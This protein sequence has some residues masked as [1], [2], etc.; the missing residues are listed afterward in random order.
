MCDAWCCLFGFLFN[1]LNSP[2]GHSFCFSRCRNEVSGGAVYLLRAA[3]L[4]SSWHGVQA[5]G[6]WTWGSEQS[7]TPPSLDENS[8]SFPCL[9]SGFPITL[10]FEEWIPLRK[11]LCSPDRPIPLCLLLPVTDFGILDWHAIPLPLSLLSAP[12]PT[13]VAP[14]CLVPLRDPSTPKGIL[15]CWRLRGGSGLGVSK[16]SCKGESSRW[17]CPAQFP[18][19]HRG[20][21]SYMLG[22]PAMG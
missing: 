7:P 10:W 16:D 15:R 11:S 14:L 1:P 8:C 20:H 2:P 3:Q 17:L 13:T 6:Q 21:N 22:C 12:V 5:G 18:A 9:A 4:V 19:S